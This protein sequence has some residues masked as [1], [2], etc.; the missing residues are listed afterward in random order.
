MLNASVWIVRNTLVEQTNIINE[1]W[2]PPMLWS[3]TAEQ[4][5]VDRSNGYL[6]IDSTSL[7]RL[8]DTRNIRWD[9]HRVLE[10]KQ[11]LRKK[12]LGYRVEASTG[13]FT[14]WQKKWCGELKQ[15]HDC[16]KRRLISARQPLE[17]IEDFC[18]G[19]ASIDT[20]HQRDCTAQHYKARVNSE[21]PV[22]IWFQVNV[23]ECTAI[24]LCTH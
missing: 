16:W 9:V 15:A 6:L 5:S 14:K 11:A 23:T 21:G 24:E 1:E 8:E 3:A 13:T 12:S 20:V 22:V 4:I 2:K 18:K 17:T 19:S 7:R 10:N